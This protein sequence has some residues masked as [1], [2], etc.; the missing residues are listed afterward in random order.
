MFENIHGIDTYGL[1]TLKKMSFSL[2]LIG[3]T[4]IDVIDVKRCIRMT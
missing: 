2:I 3:F 1:K 4:N